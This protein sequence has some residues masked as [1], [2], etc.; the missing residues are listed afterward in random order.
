VIYE[1]CF[2]VSLLVLLFLTAY[3]KGVDPKAIIMA[4]I[5][6]VGNGGYY[7]LY[8]ASNA[9]EA[10]LAN[11]VMYITG[12]F[13][14]LLMFLIICN[15]CMIRIP[16]TIQMIMYVVQVGLYLS[17]CATGRSTLFYRTI[18]FDNSGNGAYLSK[19]YGPMHMAY[20]VSVCIYMFGSIAIALFS[21]KVKNKVSTSNINIL[22]FAYMTTV[23]TYLVERLA[24][25]RV[26]LM[27]VVFTIGLIANIIVLFKIYRYKVY[28]NSV[29][30]DDHFDNIGYIIFNQNLMYMGS[31]D[32][33]MNLFPEL[34]DWELE[35]KIPG[36]GGRF[37]TFL[38]QPFMKFVQDDSRDDK[39]TG[40][41]EYR[42][43]T[44]EYKMIC[45]KSG[46][47]TRGYII[48]VGESI[49]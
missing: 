33:A 27:P 43:N 32:L 10:I 15:V 21:L 4:I 9:E 45:M 23:I 30:I 44:Y 1:I 3:G 2:L 6:A 24:S 41:F 47:R 48:E 38:R 12:M 31:N 39:K 42:D 13:G 19:T 22:L 14:P 25:L 36:S 40:A 11:K 49:I 37:N 20:L 28:G 7:A 18:A 16:D 17:V 8:L 46:R 26:E 5:I 35:K 34:K 29:V